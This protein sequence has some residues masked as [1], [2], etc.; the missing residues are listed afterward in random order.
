LKKVLVI[1]PHFAPVNAP[2]MQRARLV[3]PYLRAHGWEPVLLA[4]APELIEGAVVEPLLEA[5]YPAD[6]RIVRVRGI[7]PRFTRRLGLGGLWL[8]CGR[9][10]RQ[11][12]ERLLRTEKFDMVFF[13]T[14]QFD[15]FT[16]GPVW[17]RRFGVPYVLDYQD[18]WVTD[19]YRRTGA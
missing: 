17:K 13:T 9:A 19:H 16:L 4:I 10:F 5:T 7:P 12:G 6:I 8:R 11:A 18:P 14:T 3:L 1:S 15:A 2:D